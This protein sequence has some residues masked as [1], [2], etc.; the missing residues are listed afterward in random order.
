MYICAMSLCHSDDQ[1]IENND[2]NIELR[3]CE[4]YEIV[5]L[6]KQ[7]VSMEV[8]PAYGEVGFSSIGRH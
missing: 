6:S 2:T 1:N 3:T 5:K 4:A 8:N 7:K